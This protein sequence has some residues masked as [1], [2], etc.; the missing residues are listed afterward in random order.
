MWAWA[1]EADS[2]LTSTA[3]LAVVPSALLDRD[4]AGERCATTVYEV[5][6]RVHQAP[7]GFLV[8]GIAR[9]VTPTGP[10]PVGPGPG[11]ASPRSNDDT[12]M[13]QPRSTEGRLFDL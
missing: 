6:S 10:S 1:P 7:Q 9:D 4:E 13:D 11:D 3:G 5:A 8:L 2:L 12:S